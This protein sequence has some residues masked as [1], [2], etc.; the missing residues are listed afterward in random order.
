MEDANK[1]SITISLIL[2][3]IIFLTTIVVRFNVLD[4]LEEQACVLGKRSFTTDCFYYSKMKLLLFIS[5]ILL[6]YF[7][8]LVVNN[9][10]K[11]IKNRTYIFMITYTFMI[12]L[13]AVIS[14]NKFTSFIGMINRYEGTITL[15]CYVILMFVAMNISEN[16]KAIK[17]VV[18][19]LLLTA[20]CVGIIGLFQYLNLD[21]FNTNLGKALIVSN[22]DK[23]FRNQLKFSFE[24]GM[25]Y[26]TL[27][28]P[29]Y[30]GSYTSVLIPFIST[31]MIYTKNK[32]HKILFLCLDILMIINLIGSNSRGG[33]VSII[34]SSILIILIAIKS[35]KISLRK[36]SIIIFL[37]IFSSVI[38]NKIADNRITENIASISKEIVNM[39]ST[40]KENCGTRVKSIDLID[41]DTIEFSENDKNLYL[42]FINNNYI[43]I[44]NENN[45]LSLEQ[46][47][48]NG[49]FKVLDENFENYMFKLGNWNGNEAI[50]VKEKALDVTFVRK[51]EELQYLNL[52]NGEIYEVRDVEKVGFEGKERLGS[53]R[54]YIWSRTIPLL[55][56]TLILGYGPDN[57]AIHFPK[58]DYVGIA[59][60]YQR[61]VII[62]KPH[63]QYLNIAVNTGI[64]SLIIYL[65]MHIYYITD[66]IKIYS[67]IEVNDFKTIL[68]LAIFVSIFGYLIVNIFNDSVLG[69]APSAWILTGMGIGINYNVKFIKKEYLKRLKMKLKDKRGKNE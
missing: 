35:K 10:L 46:D 47:K 64:I 65:S 67:K 61:E 59:N 4:I 55:K 8:Y 25:V 45:I 27:G 57:F 33:V 11:L 15:I 1:N 48:E 5:L 42:K 69:V 63:S 2:A 6:I 12:L 40:T 28:N 39:F 34:C 66:S 16:D 31:F 68:G 20:T 19:S 13:S 56:K 50:Q 17:I 52:I 54:G 23:E 44:D 3:S 24:K 43:V 49:F 60:S 9:K 22:K 58:N 32:L 62:D 21:F 41:K 29:N 18:V 37:L 51:N 14:K 7:T 26:S 36:F 30:V 38:V 53:N